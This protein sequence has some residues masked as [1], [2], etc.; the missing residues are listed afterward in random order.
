MNFKKLFQPLRAG[1]ESYLGKTGIV[2]YA[3]PNSQTSTPLQNLASNQ[4]LRLIGVAYGISMNAVADTVI[5]PINTT[6]Y[7][8]ASVFVTNATASLAQATG[9]LFTLPAAGGTAIV[10][11]AAL[12]GATTA[13]KVVSQTVASTDIPTT[14]PL[15]Y[16]VAVVN[17]ASATADV[18]VY[19]YAFDSVL[20]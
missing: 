15:Y 20:P 19:G 11:A 12:S 10:A 4:A 5:N 3:A 1:I 16:R 8:V 14:V 18:Y 9:G 17:T 7:S 6:K 2:L 13:Q